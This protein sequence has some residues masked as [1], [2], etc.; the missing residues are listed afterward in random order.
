MMSNVLYHA[1]I[2]RAGTSE[3]GYEEPIGADVSAIKPY[4]VENFFF[5]RRAEDSEISIFSRYFDTE[6]RRYY[7]E[8]FYNLRTDAEGWVK[9]VSVK[10]ERQLCPVENRAEDLTPTLPTTDDLWRAI[11]PQVSE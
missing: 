4:L 7:I 9:V 8:I 6:K 10:P 1:R 11:A 2:R 5:G 3:P